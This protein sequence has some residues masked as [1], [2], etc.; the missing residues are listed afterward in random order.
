MEIRQGDI[1]WIDEAEPK[2]SEPGFRRPFVVIQNNVFNASR[3]RT[4]VMCAVTTNLRRADAPGNVLLREGEGGLS[5]AS[6]VNV[7]QIF[8][9]DK[10]ELADYCGSLSGKRIG[11]ILA[12]IDLL[13]QP[14]DIEF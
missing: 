14:A 8:T 5:K 9:V 10:N 7:T 4:T 3:L 11:E 13:L 2:G 6:V 1:F 12:G